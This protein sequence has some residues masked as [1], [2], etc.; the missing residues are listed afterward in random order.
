LSPIP[1]AS[2]I[3]RFAAAPIRIVANAADT[4]VARMASS[5]GMP[6]AARNTGFTTAM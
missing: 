6:A 2:A 1:G 5:R 4:I 3:G